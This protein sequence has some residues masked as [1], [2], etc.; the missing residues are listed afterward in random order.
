MNFHHVGILVN[1][2]IEYFEAHFVSELGISSLQGPVLDDNQKARTAMIST[3]PGAGIELVS[4]S[5]AGSPL[6]AALKAGGGLHHLCYE[7]DD[8]EAAFATLRE[9]GLVPVSA[10]TPAV[11]FE[12]LRVAF[13]FS[14]TGGLIELVESELGAA[15]E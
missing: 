13:L 9:R 11:L 8:I 7:V 15:E 1:D 10:P 5:E 6:S 3:G 2:I 4:P 14:R 12:G